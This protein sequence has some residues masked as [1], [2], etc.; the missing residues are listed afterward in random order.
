VPT[1]QGWQEIDADKDYSV[2]VPDYLYRG[3]DGY[4]IPKDRPA[5]PPG[6]EL[7]YLVLDGILRAQALGEKVGAPVDPANPRFHQLIEGKQPCFR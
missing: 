3:G 2:V 7:K 1:E 6:S 4:E 5:S